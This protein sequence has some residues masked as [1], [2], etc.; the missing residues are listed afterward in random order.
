[1]E[2]VFG[3]WKRWGDCGGAFVG[4]VTGD[5]FEEIDRMSGDYFFDRICRI[6]RIDRITEGLLGV[7]GVF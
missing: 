3:G 2:G 1:V 5:F 7:V 4:F 6:C